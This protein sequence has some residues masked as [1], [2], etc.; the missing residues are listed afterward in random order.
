MRLTITAA[1][2][3]AFLSGCGGNRAGKPKAPPVP[4]RESS[5]SD[6]VAAIQGS[7]IGFDPSRWTN[8]PPVGVGSVNVATNITLTILPEWHYLGETVGR[9]FWFHWWPEGG[10][11][12]EWRIS[13]STNLVEW[14]TEWHHSIEQEFTH[15]RMPVI[16]FEGFTPAGEQMRFHRFEKI[17]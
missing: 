14:R 2:I 13:S 15:P 16:F 4:S 9:R 5:R 11:A 7:S 3:A 8:A 10:D 12:K 6:S 17:R 1:L